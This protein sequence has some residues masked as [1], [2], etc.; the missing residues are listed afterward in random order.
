MHPGRMREPRSRVRPGHGPALILD[1]LHPV[2]VDL[3]LFRRIRLMQ[4]TV[5]ELTQ[6]ITPE[7]APVVE[8]TV[9]DV[10]SKE[11][12]TQIAIQSRA[13]RKVRKF[14]VVRLIDER[15]GFSW[16]QCERQTD[17]C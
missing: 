7:T 16:F 4:Q 8:R 6:A 2:G 1:V 9:V 10:A 15:H 5:C 12:R 3:L 17:L 13:S 11:P 14:G